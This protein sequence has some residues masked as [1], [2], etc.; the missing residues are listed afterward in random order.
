MGPALTENGECRV[1]VS[2]RGKW[3]EVPALRVNG[4]AIIVQGRWLKIAA[5]HEEQWLES[6]V[7]DPEPFVR[8]LKEHGA[9]GSHADIFTFALK[10]PAERS[11]FDYPAESQSLAAVRITTFNQWWE[12]LP[13]ETRKNVRRAKKRSIEVRVDPLDDPLVA[14][15]VGVNN[16]SP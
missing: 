15:I 4:K 14:G 13:Q 10:P 16:D 2:V 11:R 12:K 5:I 9:P 8:A 6:E 7:E 3:T 1:E